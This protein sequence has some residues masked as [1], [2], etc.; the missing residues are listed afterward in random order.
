[1]TAT[2]PGIR[3]LVLDLDGCLVRGPRA[4]PGAPEAVAALRARGCAVRF[5]TNDSAKTQAETAERLGIAGIAAA[6]DEVL[7]SATVAAD[8]VAKRFPHGHVLIV[9]AAALRSA[10][11]ERG[12]SVV[13]APPADAAV[14]GRD[15]DFTYAKLDAVCR[16][17]WDGTAFLAT[18]LDRRMP[19]AGG[20][21]PGTG[22]LVKA[23]A[24]ATATRPLVMG[25]PSR[26]AGRAAVASLGLPAR[27]VAVVGD[28][29]LQDV[30]MGKLAGTATV[31]VLTGSSTRDEVERAPARLRPDAVLPDV[32]SLPG[33]LA[34]I[35]ARGGEG[36]EQGEPVAASP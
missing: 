27:E 36:A 25:K 5:F 35:A 11:E 32:G 14:V 19:V 22:S 12:L 24:W 15:V 21:V 31:L 8:Y 34:G 30:R 29:L 1:M 3:G 10:L 23:V 20:F 2:P 26:W 33:W 6:A 17:I 28:A 9:G 18:N 4:I 16:A 13:D 7:S